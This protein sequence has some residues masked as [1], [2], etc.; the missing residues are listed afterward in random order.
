MMLCHKSTTLQAP[1][2]RSDVRGKQDILCTSRNLLYIPE[3]PPGQT[4]QAIE[5]TVWLVKHFLEALGLIP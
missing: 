2:W 4:R 1:K 3:K 5:L